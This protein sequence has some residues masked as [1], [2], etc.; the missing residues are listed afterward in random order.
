MKILLFGGGLGN[1]IFEYGFYYYLRSR[2]SNERIYG[3]YP[4]WWLNEHNGLEI[5]KWFEVN[6]PKSNLFVYFLSGFFFLLKKV[7]PNSRLLDLSNREL[8]NED[9]IFFNAFK[10]SIDF[11]PSGNDWLPFKESLELSREN[12]EILRAINSSNSVFLHVRRGDYLSEKY[13]SR[14]DNTC[15]VEYYMKAV[16]KVLSIFDNPTFFCFSDDIDWVKSNLNIENAHYIDWN[17]G[18]SSFFD[19][20]LMSQC[21][22]GIIANSTFS[23]WGARLGKSKKVVVYPK[24]WINSVRQ[25]DI[26]PKW[27]IDI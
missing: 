21:C 22:G 12:V 8:L 16:S 25:P 18:D 27:W 11:I 5:H 3:I 7:R 24:H 23:Y 6:L 15:T 10:L 1:Q 9:A 13:K 17:R 4:N 2:S 20:Y 19:M 14:F 26:F